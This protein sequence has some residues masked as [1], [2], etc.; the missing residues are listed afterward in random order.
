MSAIQETDT[1]AENA[2][3]EG[4]FPLTFQHST[5]NAWSAGGGKVQ[6]TNKDDNSEGW[7]STTFELTFDATISF[8]W[9]V[10]SEYSDR[11]YFYVDGR[12]IQSIGGTD[13]ANFSEVTHQL[14]PGVHTIKWSYQKNGGTTAGFDEA[15]V[16]N[17]FITPDAFV[18]AGVGRPICD[19]QIYFGNVTVNTPITKEVHLTNIGTEAVTINSITTEAPFSIGDYT[20]T[21]SSLQKITIPVTLTSTTEG[22][23]EGKAI[24][25]TNYGT[26]EITLRA[27]SGAF[28]HQYNVT[29]PG[30][31]NTLIPEAELPNII[32]VKLSGSINKTDIDFLKIKATALKTLDLSEATLENNT[33]GNSFFHSSTTLET[34]ILPTGIT[35]IES[36]AFAESPSLKQVVIPESVNFIGSQAFL[37]C[38][39]LESIALPSALR[40]LEGSSFQGC[41]NL[42]EVVIPELLQN[43]DG[44]AFTGC[45]GLETV[46]IGNGV[47]SL[48]GYYQ[49]P[50]FEGCD[51]L[52]T[53]VIGDGITKLNNQFTGKTKLTSVTLGKNLQELHGTFNGCT[54]L[55]TITLPDELRTIGD[56]TFNGCT[57]LTTINF[58]DSTRT[59]GT[60]AFYNCSKLNGIILNDSLKNIGE[61]AFTNCSSLTE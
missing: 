54:A 56:N 2:L 6:S 31:I 53:L 55:E 25:S 49:T 32:S 5:T 17:I 33:V 3:K 42:K 41:T 57:G 61:Q 10:N 35:R 40:T 22:N 13:M 12:E 11:L 23:I 39:A 15:Q 37:N 58:P 14:A 60:T 50:V 52:T 46:K 29:T 1:F 21:I 27:Y 36:S 26:K 18:V 24:V 45:S 47:T 8:E 59:I 34:I 4:S 48:G 44:Y 51:N 7:F 43:I 16:R 9:Y 38:P 30:T 20:Q 28:S 19:S